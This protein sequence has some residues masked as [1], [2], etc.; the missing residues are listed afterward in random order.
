[1]SIQ[2]L[3]G[4]P[5]SVDRYK[6]FIDFGKNADGGGVLTVRFRIKIYRIC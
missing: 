1:M 5:A 3:D 2:H 6:Y 4:A